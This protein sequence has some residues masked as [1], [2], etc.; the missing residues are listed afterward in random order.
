MANLW[1]E[2][3]IFGVQL[4]CFDEGGFCNVISVLLK[5][6]MHLATCCSFEKVDDFF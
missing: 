1:C 6:Q 5:I 4:F 3:G 2:C